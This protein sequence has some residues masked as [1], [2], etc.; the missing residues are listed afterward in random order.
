MSRSLLKKSAVRYTAEQQ[1]DAAE[2][3][4]LLGERISKVARELG[5]SPLSVSSWIKKY[6]GKIEADYPS[7]N[8]SD[9]SDPSLDTPDSTPVDSDPPTQRIMPQPG[10]TNG[11]VRKKAVKKALPVAP[12][13]SRVEIVSR[14]GVVVKLPGDVSPDALHGIVKRLR[15]TE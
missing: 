8:T 13:L 7:A 4:L 9:T 2:S 14:G 15:K 5:C 1:K 10:R 3:V 11:V 12:P 6:Q